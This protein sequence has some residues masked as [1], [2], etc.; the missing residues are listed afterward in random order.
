MCRKGKG[1]EGKKEEG[2]KEEK[3][4]VPSRGA[5][6][7]RPILCSPLAISPPANV[8]STRSFFSST[9]KPVAGRVDSVLSWLLPRTAASRT[10][11]LAACRTRC[12]VGSETLIVISA[13]P[14]KVQD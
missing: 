11:G 5:F 6:H 10:R 8:I 14:V 9:L 7:L 12:E 4:S 3:N 13:V 2:S 1:Q